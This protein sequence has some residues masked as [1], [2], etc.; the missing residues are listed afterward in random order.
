VQAANELFLVQG[1]RI[2]MILPKLERVARFNRV[3][4]GKGCTMSKAVIVLLLVMV[5]GLGQPGFNWLTDIREKDH[6]EEIRSRLKADITELA[7]PRYSTAEYQRAVDYV[8]AQAQQLGL[9]PVPEPVIVSQWERGAATCHLLLPQKSPKEL[10]IVALTGSAAGDVE[11]QVVLVNYF[12][13]A[14]QGPPPHRFDEGNKKRIV[15]FSRPLREDPSVKE[16]EKTVV[17]RN[18]G[19]RWAAKYGAAAVLVRSVQTGDGP[20]HTGAVDYDSHPGIP[21]VALSMAAAD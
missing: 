11:A 10:D 20:P 16:Y 3:A 14:D 6:Q 13:D 5:I 15:F 1:L 21:A 8:S 4:E 9:T 18:D 17:Q 19:A 12:F 7:K 2:A